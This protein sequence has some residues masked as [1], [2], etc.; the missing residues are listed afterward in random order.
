MLPEKN[1]NALREERFSQVVR[2]A[3]GTSLMGQRASGHKGEKNHAVG[4]CGF[5][6]F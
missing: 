3:A 2:Q 4:G 5:G 1:G 6:L